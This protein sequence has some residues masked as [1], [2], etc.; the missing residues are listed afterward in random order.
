[1]NDAF[2]L[3]MFFRTITISEGTFFE[4]VGFVFLKT[5][6]DFF[7]NLRNICKRTFYSYETFLDRAISISV[8]SKF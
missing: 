6:I 2:F 8:K 1:M 4:S 5:A 3:F 7:S